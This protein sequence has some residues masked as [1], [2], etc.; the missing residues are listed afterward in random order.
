MFTTVYERSAVFAAEASAL[1]SGQDTE[2]TTQDEAVPS[3]D[4]SDDMLLKLHQAGYPDAFGMLVQ[5]HR[6]ACLAIATRI[7]RDAAQA[8]DEVQTAFVKAYLACS[9]L[10][11]RS[12]FSAWLKQVVTNQCRTHIR[13]ERSH[14]ICSINGS[15]IQLRSPS[16]S[17][18]DLLV[19]KE[20][21]EVVRREAGRLPSPMRTVFRLVVLEGKTLQQCAEHLGIV[22]ANVKSRLA[23]A[24]CELRSRM[25]KF[26]AA[27]KAP[28]VQRKGD[29][30]N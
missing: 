29:G 18:E 13:T 27:G 9:G 2:L 12:S 4:M 7:L 3:M 11:V 26:Y 8:E 6:H 24:R 14:Q 16:R 28:R 20:F 15:T 22:E 19:E 25:K 23:R 17:H 5:R 10:Q 21:A 1:S 30:T